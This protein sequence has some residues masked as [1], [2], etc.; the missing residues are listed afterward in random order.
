MA[1]TPIGDILPYMNVPH[2]AIAKSNLQTY[3][4]KQGLSGL[5]PYE[6]L[7]AGNFIGYL[8][9]WYTV[10]NSLYFIFYKNLSDY[11]NF[12]NSYSVKY[13]DYKKIAF[14]NVPTWKNEGINF[15]ATSSNIQA[16]I[17]RD[18][19]E[20]ESLTSI[21]SS[22]INK[23]ILIGAIYLGITLIIKRNNGN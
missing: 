1:K 18:N 17:D 9:S 5:Q 13:S 7:V 10:G 11:N 12:K 23:I 6:K 8:D 19:K 3:I 14:P 22:S 4:Y 20:A 2:Y 15:G 21:I 16:I